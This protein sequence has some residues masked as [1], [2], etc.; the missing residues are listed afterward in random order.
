MSITFIDFLNKIIAIPDFWIITVL[1]T[2]V[3]FVNGCTDAPNSIAT[4]VSTR[5]LTPAKALTLSVIFSF[6]GILIMTFIN[7]TV[8]QTI[9]NIVDFGNNT[10]HA[11]TA[12]CAALGAIVIWAI[13]AWALGI[14]TSESHALIAGLTGSAIALQNGISGVNM[15]EWRKVIYG[16][17]IVNILGFVSGL[18]ITKLIEKICKNMDRRKTN[19]FFH[20]SQIA[21]AAAMAFMHGA[22]D[23]QKFMG[24]FLL[25][26]ML[27]TGNNAGFD[28]PIWLTFYCAIFTALGAIIG[29]KKIIKT[30]G[31]KMV[32]L[33]KY[34]GTSADIASSCCLLGSSLLGIPVSTTHVKTTAIMGVGASKGFSK[35]NWNI[36][37]NM[38]LTW[39]FTFPGCGL[40]GYLLTKVFTQVF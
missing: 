10:Q 2:G 34:Q 40:L 6:L 33:E 31:V 29:G 26:A 20:K 5:C 36:A 18:V 9:F 22:Q 37:K 17:I 7:S 25:G 16:L 3:M 11:L 15:G 1:I 23:G 24:V 19:K 8:A 32:K 21:G 39:I 12:L 30:V 35:V 14:P 27:A 38:V 13:T 28:I 4:C